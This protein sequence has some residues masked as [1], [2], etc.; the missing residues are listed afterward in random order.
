MK[1]FN[2]ENG[3]YHKTLWM[4]LLVFII[5]LFWIP[6]YCFAKDSSLELRRAR[7]SVIS[8]ELSPAILIHSTA[9]SVTLFG[10]LALWGLGE[11]NHLAMETKSGVYVMNRSEGSVLNPPV[12]HM[13]A[14]WMLVWF[15]G[16]KGWNQWD[17]AWLVVWQHRLRKVSLDSTG[18]HAYLKDGV[19]YIALMPLYGLYKPRTALWKTPPSDVVRKC[20]FWSRVLLRYPVKC[21]ETF[22]ID[23]KADSVVIRDRFHWIAWA[24]DWRTA[25]LKFAP[26]SPT[27]ALAYMGG[28][29]PVRFSAK[30]SNPG[31]FTSYGPY[32]GCANCDAYEAYFPVLHYI[33]QTEAVQKPDLSDPIVAQAY[34]RLQ[35][36]MRATFTSADGLFHQDFGDPTDFNQPPPQK[37]D[38]GNTCWALMSAQYYCRGL[39]YLPSQLKAEAKARLHRYFADWVLQ[40]ERYKPFKGKL[41]LV[42]PGIGTWGG[43]DDAGKFSSNVLTTLWAYAQY[44]G[45]WSLIKQRWPLIKKLF[46]TPRECSWRGFGRDSIA[47]MGD[48]AS[49]P[50][51]FARMAYRIG[52]KLGFAWGAY[53]FVRELTHLMVKQTG[54][55]YFVKHQPVDSMEKMPDDVYLTNLWGD[56]AGWQIDGPTYPKHTGER[57]YNNRWVRFGDPDVARFLRD[58]AEVLVRREL[59]GLLNSGRFTAERKNSLDDPHIL[60]SMVRLCSLLL[61]ESPDQLATI[62][63]VNANVYPN[64]GVIAYCASFLRTS[65]PIRFA[66]IIPESKTKTGWLEG[67]ERSRPKDEPVLDC[68]VNWTCGANHTPG[69]IAL[70][71]WGWS[72]PRTDTSVPGGDRWS[73]GQILP[74]AGNTQGADVRLSWNSSAIVIPTDSPIKAVAKRRQ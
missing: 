4:A 17:S 20:E 46:V 72:P 27:L 32:M 65:R 73:F 49:P 52:D 59:K 67:L 41:L 40:P 56:T 24:D 69:P 74:D 23:P 58:H 61:D 28:G 55:S 35:D 18:L 57:Q 42:G 25:P 11:P 6:Q 2:D 14:P 12:S 70:T 51:A 21:D 8:S 34:A 16:A 47:E 26:I 68:V 43:Y 60:P 30:I 62:T 7:L 45:D 13:S 31:L 29:M 63:P 5:T 53:I 3:N 10:N 38:G 44:S 22:R 50:L 33:T 71:W 36:A 19:G 1:T 48:E 37:S 15:H 39:A 66:N 54:A 9:K 64:S